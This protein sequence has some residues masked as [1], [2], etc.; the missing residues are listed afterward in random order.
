LKAEN[1]KYF[2]EQEQSIT[3]NTA[4]AKLAFQ[5]EL[6]ADQ[7]SL[8]ARKLLNDQYYERTKEEISAEASARSSEDMKKLSSGRFVA[9]KMKSL[10]AE[11]SLR[12]TK[13]AYEQEELDKKIKL[14][15]L[16]ALNSYAAW[17]QDTQQKITENT[18]K[19]YGKRQ[20]VS[21]AAWDAIVE[22][23]RLAGEKIKEIDAD[24]LN[25]MLREYKETF[26]GGWKQG[27]IEIEDEYGNVGKQMTDATKRMFDNMTESLTEFVMTGKLNF[28]DFAN[29]V[30]KDLV[31]IMIQKNITGPLAGAG[32]DWLSS[33]FGTDTSTTTSATG[34]GTTTISG[35]TSGVYYN[36]IGQHQGGVGNEATFYRIVPSESFAN[37]PRYHTGIGPGEKAAIIKDDEGV[38]T[39]GQMKAMGLMANNSSQQ[40]IKVELVNQSGTQ[41]QST[42]SETK[43]NGQE[44]VVTVWLDALNR[45]YN[46]LRDALGG[47]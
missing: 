45:N 23:E 40:N 2:D 38:F 27:L 25:E 12:K 13:T 7:E 15:N 17:D 18:S 6:L 3:H 47:G 1:K 22:Y 28:A 35:N 31:R 14:S 19:E 5:N 21:A 34:S 29:S 36:A 43:F 11:M 33:L 42:K 8:N 30:I 4:M 37:A 20:E 24:T 10:D 9:D 41:M 39:A 16:A 46:G 26:V 32:S 44:Y